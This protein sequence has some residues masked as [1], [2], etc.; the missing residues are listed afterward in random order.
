MRDI[1][2]CVC[3]LKKIYYTMA[4]H[5]KIWVCISNLFF[6]CFRGEILGSCMFRMGILAALRSKYKKGIQ[7][8][9]MSLFKNSYCVCNP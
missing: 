7:L 9:F 6:L 4:H 3:F 1:Q 2:E 5:H 8:F